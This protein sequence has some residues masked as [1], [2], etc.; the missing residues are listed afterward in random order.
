MEIK[1]K[2]F[3]TIAQALDKLKK[4]FDKTDKSLVKTQTTLDETIINIDNVVDSVARTMTEA[5]DPY[6]VDMIYGYID[7]NGKFKLG[8]IKDPWKDEWSNIIPNNATRIYHFG[9]TDS[10]KNI[11]ILNNYWIYNRPNLIIDILDV[12][13]LF[14]NI[15]TWNYELIS[16]SNVNI[17]IVGNKSLY[18]SAY[19]A[20]YLIT[21][22][23]IT[24]LIVNKTDYD[25][26]DDEVHCANNCIIKS[27]KLNNIT[28]LNKGFFQSC[29][30]LFQ[31][32]LDIEGFENIEK[33]DNAIL[34]N[35]YASAVIEGL[36][37]LVLPEKLIYFS[38]A[39]SNRFETVN[40]Q[41]SNKKIRIGI[42]YKKLKKIICTYSNLVTYD[43]NQPLRNISNN[44]IQILSDENQTEETVNDN[45][46]IHTEIIKK[47]TLCK[48]PYL[49]N[50][51][52]NKNST[53]ILS[54]IESG[55][56]GDIPNLDGIYISDLNVFFNAIK[57]ITYDIEIWN[58]NKTSINSRWSLYQNT[59]TPY[60]NFSI[61]NFIT[62]IP[63]RLFENCI[64]G[65]IDLNNVKRIG[66]NAFCNAQINSLNLRNV[67][68]IST[69]ALSQL[70]LDKL[71]IPSTITRIEFSIFKNS[72]F[73]ILIFP[74]T[75]ESLHEDATISY[76]DKL[77]MKFNPQNV[78][79]TGIMYI[80][81][82]KNCQAFYVPAEYIDIYKKW[83]SWK[84]YADKIFPY[85]FELNPDN[86]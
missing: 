30:F 80:E 23:H 74:D 5:L 9:D 16:T 60:Y 38:D 84:K 49:K 58:F 6:F 8:V 37:T 33:Y 34:D 17:L 72:Q 24:Q 65:D 62:D 73:K 54:I 3:T 51:F 21:A 53:I 36:N 22:S 52:I 28:C 25:I 18:R 75:L 2:L 56:L 48:F 44:D 79:I 13:K 19:Y 68:L 71:D 70:T 78:S 42:K 31:S 45:V 46:Y 66:Q 11:I 29:K 41:G 7:D 15:T 47:Y 59:N 14:P 81:P 55:A 67:E 32:T 35:Q 27:I 39:N 43:L 64:L 69:G 40:L 83:A 1:F 4:Q 57:H 86:I 76:C 82:Y 12:D 85:D 50:I 77:Y 10:F 63:S 61:P 26:N 20:P